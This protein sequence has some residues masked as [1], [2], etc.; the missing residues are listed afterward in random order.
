MRSILLLVLLACHQAVMAG[1]PPCDLGLD[2]ILERYVVERGGHEAIEHQH[3]LRIV[4]THHEGQWNPK[5]DYRVMKPGYMWIEA[6]YDDGAIITEGFDGQRGWEKWPDKP[7]IYVGGD[8]KKGVNQGAVSPVHLYGLHHMT[9]LGAQVTLRGCDSIGGLHYY[10]INVASSFGTNIDY[11]VNASTFRLE[12]SRTTR[13]LHPTQDPTPI[14]IEERW[15]DFRM[16]NGVLHPFGMSLWNVD[17]GERLSWL[18]VNHI[19]AFSDATPE[20]FRKPD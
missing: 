15:S 2:E 1:P 17:S 13:P 8:A 10:V 14:Q 20:F 19:E 5:F 3:A 9:A 11:F 7:A 12:R 6:T 16:V 18:E 4:S